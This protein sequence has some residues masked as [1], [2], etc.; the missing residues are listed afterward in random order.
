MNILSWN[1]RGLNA[2]RKRS[3]LADLIKQHSVDILAIQ[4]TKK[5]DFTKRFL[6]SISPRFDSWFWLPSIG[7][8]GGIL[9]GCDSEL[10]SVVSVIKRQF[11]L[12]VILKNRTDNVEWMYT[13]VYAPVLIT[14]KSAFWEELKQVRLSWAGIWLVSGDFNSIRTRDE[15]LGHNFNIRLS[16]KFNDFIHDSQLIEYK[17]TQRRFTWND[18]T[19]FALLDRF[20]GSIE[21]DTQYEFCFVQDLSQFGSD[22]CPLLLNTKHKP[23]TPKAPFRFDNIWLDDPEFCRLMIKWWNDFPLYGEIGKS[24]HRKIKYITQKMEGWVKN[25]EGQKKKIKKNSLEQLKQLEIIQELRD[26]SDEECLQ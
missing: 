8:S 9:F 22:H 1:I 16:R 14:L 19:H 25:N 4:E 23:P 12:S 10:V 13:I 20:F 17:L 5:E 24:W 26:L 15:K 3:I 7:R 6:K 11:S 2:C 21:W 18:G